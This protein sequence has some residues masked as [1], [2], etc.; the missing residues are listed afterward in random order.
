MITHGLISS[1]LFLLVGILYDRY[2]TR[3]ILYYRGL[4][5]IMPLFIF[6]FFIFTMA[7]IAFPGTGS[8][9]SE[10]LTFLGAFQNN[11]IL[12]LL[13]TIVIPL[14]PCYA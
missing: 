3:T 9:I 4:V 5:L 7:N 10:F 11:P 13:G 14:G 8:F 12:T 6:F 2:H 1:G